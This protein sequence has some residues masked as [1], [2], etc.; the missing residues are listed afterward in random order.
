[1][2]TARRL[3][4]VTVGVLLSTALA[5]GI[6]VFLL[7]TRSVRAPRLSTAPSSRSA[8]EG[9][10]NGPRHSDAAAGVA[11]GAE[12]GSKVLAKLPTV[13]DDSSGQAEDE[14]ALKRRLPI[15]L[16][17]ADYDIL[18]RVDEVVFRALSTK[19]SARM[20]I[21]RFN[22]RQRRSGN[23]RDDVGGTA[24]SSFRQAFLEDLLGMDEAAQFVAQELKETN[25]LSHGREIAAHADAM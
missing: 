23:I 19:D 21:R 4:P 22:S 6:C 25:R 3:S 17:M 13:L 24:P 14:V 20:A 7:G 16:G 2:T 12:Q 11:F 8:G 18:R 5:V 1:M 9:L 10:L 15:D